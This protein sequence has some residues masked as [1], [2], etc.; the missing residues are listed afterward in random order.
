MFL[1]SLPKVTV[2]TTMN[3]DH[4]NGDE[5]DLGSP[6]L[7]LSLKFKAFTVTLILMVGFFHSDSSFS[8][9]TNR[10]CTFSFQKPLNVASQA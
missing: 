6:P 2:M 9:G 3:S 4:K 8:N 10:V 5:H 1:V 7:P